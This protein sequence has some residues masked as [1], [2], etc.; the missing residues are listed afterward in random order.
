MG[1]LFGSLMFIAPVVRTSSL[2]VRFPVSFANGY[3][4]YYFLD[5]FGNEIRRS[6]IYRA[7]MNM[8]AFN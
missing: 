7:W 6:S 5:D 1:G 4:A 8:I 3:L 2:F